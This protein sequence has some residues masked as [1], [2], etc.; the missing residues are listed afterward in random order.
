[1]R[2]GRVESLVW[3]AEADPAPESAMA[4]VGEL[5]IL[6]PLQGLIDRDAELARLDREIQ[7]LG[8]DLPRIE[9]K[10]D[11]PAFTARAPAAVVAKERARADELRNTLR[12]LEQQSAKIRQL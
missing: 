1:M 4:R 9:A 2:L 5:R 12:E 3:L 11:D 7:R 6:I 10:L 8:K